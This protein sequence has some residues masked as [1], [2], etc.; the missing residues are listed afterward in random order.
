MSY[1]EFIRIVEA[2]A[3]IGWDEA[4]RASRAVLET[5]AERI[6]RG[7]ARDLAER[8]PPELAPS[9]GSA[10]DAQGFDADEF[11]RRVAVRAGVD[12][13]R[14]E[15]YARAVFTA[16]WRAVG[17]SEF[18]DVVAELPGDFAPLLPVGPQVQVVSLD[19][20]LAHVADRAA[21]DRERASHIAEAV[22]ET[23]GERIAGGEVKDLLKYLP[24]ALHEPL[25]RGDAASGGKAK[26]MSLDEFVDTVAMREGEISYE[27]ALD[28]T[29]AVLATLRE[30][31][32]DKEFRDIDSQLPSDYDPVLA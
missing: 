6:A 3:E 26:A 31:I 21:T 5:L 16:V 27:Q 10:D 24:R 19:T 1:E 12:Q 4:E 20:F 32:P 9:L 11:I 23:L 30:T 14:A 15:R 8:L 25:K 2:H 13:E 29:R 18:D 22:L 7:E 17:R 28:H